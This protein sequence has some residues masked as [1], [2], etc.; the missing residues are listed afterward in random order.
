M[1]R[2]LK[3]Y[4]ILWI[5]NL[6]LLAILGYILIC[7]IDGED[8]NQR[9]VTSSMLE[10]PEAEVILNKD[11]LPAVNHRIILERNVFG[12]PRADVT[13]TAAKKK[14][15]VAR[16]AKPVVRRQLE[17]RLLGTV[18][19]DEQVACAV[20][21][22]TRT[23]VQDLYM[24]GDIIQGARIERIERNRMILLNEDGREVLNLYVASEDS[25][26]DERAGESF[27]AKKQSDTDVVKIV[28]PNKR[29]INKKAFLAKVGGMSAVLKRVK[30][31]PYIVDGEAK[32][33]RINGLENFSL[34]KY[35]GLKDGDVIQTINGQ[36]MTN[37]RKAFQVL[38]RARA[39][40]SSDVQLLSG[41]EKKTLSFRIR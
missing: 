39:L 11:S 24:T 8:D 26:P 2:F 22:D 21:E 40:S 28:S 6:G 3:P 7:F 14:G 25:V 10:V 37:R 9:P 16:P 33:I 4:R 20:V 12:S 1:K 32:G 30:L 27:V 13:K 15:Q 38:R 29:E 35:V 19:G 36:K 5:V 34:A 17:L 41:R 18:A 31:S 23:K